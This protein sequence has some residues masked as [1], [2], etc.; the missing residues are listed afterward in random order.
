MSTDGYNSTLCIG[1]D[2]TWWG[3]SPRRKTSQRDTIVAGIVGGDAMLPLFI[4]P[5]D[6]SLAPNQQASDP[7]EP[8]FDAEGR[9]L[10]NAIKDVLKRY[11]GQFSKCVIALDAP[12]EASKRLN[13]PA[14]RRAVGKGEVMGSERRQ[15]EHEIGAFI[16]KHDGHA[17]WHNDL[18]IQSGSPI[19][20]R[21]ASICECLKTEL[22]FSIL[23]LAQEKHSRHIIE[24]FPSEAIWAL[25]IL[26][27]YAQ[28]N[29]A[30][31]RAYKAKTPKVVSRAEGLMLAGSSLAGFLEILQRAGKPKP[32]LDGIANWAKQIAEHCCEIASVPADSDRIIKDKGFDDPLE[33]GI[34]FL[35][36]VCFTLDEYHVFG[37]GTDGAIVGPGKLP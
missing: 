6:L 23:R 15:S 30:N 37:D 25:G 26:G 19:A 1:I 10:T 14:R 33:S 21:I 17:A 24:I 29:S 20:P 2:V 7:R 13:Q 4:H 31:V 5:V 8:N 18:N 22:K 16:R 36:A 32:M 27:C 28:Q 9:L 35:T 3:G 11:E 34:A 12:L